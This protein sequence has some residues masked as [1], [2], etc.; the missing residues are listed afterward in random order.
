MFD[1]VGSEKKKNKDEIKCD[2]RIYQFCRQR[3]KERKKAQ[4]QV[5][6]VQSGWANKIKKIKVKINK[7][8][9]KDP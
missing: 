8:L 5:A 1:S 7:P 6:F 2:E 4:R 3:K 9:N